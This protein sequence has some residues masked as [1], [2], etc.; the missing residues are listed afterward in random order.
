[1]LVLMDV[2]SFGVDPSRNSPV[3]LLKE[4][5]GPRTLAVPIGPFEAS[6][7]AMSTLGVTVEKP[8]AIDVAKLV[9]EGLGGTVDRLVI[10]EGA[11]AQSLIGRLHIYSARGL[12]LL[13]CAP[14]HGIVLALRCEAPVFVFDHVLDKRQGEESA[15]PA[16]MLRRHIA[17]LDTID[18]GC[19]HME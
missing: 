9:L 5:G 3:L 18:F 10:G 17:S 8:M 11:E 1:M 13:D 16:E 15:S 14:S 6:A 2:I 19:Y 12:A 4:S 7:L